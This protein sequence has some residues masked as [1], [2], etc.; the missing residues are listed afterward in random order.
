MNTTLRILRI[1]EKWSISYDTANNDRPKRWLRHGVIHR[2][3]EE[4][5]GTVALFYALLAAKEPT[6]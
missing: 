6:K 3:F 4:N 5:N 2:D 1:D